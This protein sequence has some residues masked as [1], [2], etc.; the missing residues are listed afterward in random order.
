[1][2]KITSYKNEEM[3][4]LK[5]EG[6]LIGKYI[7][8][9]QSYW[10]AISESHTAQRICLDLSEVTFVD[11]EGKTALAL[12]HDAGTGILATNVLTRFIV[13]EIAARE[14]QTV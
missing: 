6:R 4:M 9:L 11:S 13:E 8:E 2:L 12:I 14:N 3:V 10:L 1:M 7:D 5:L